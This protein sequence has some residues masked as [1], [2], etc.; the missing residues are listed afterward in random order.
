MLTASVD[1]QILCHRSV[2]LNWDYFCV[3]TDGTL[4]D[5]TSEIND[6]FVVRNVFFPK[7]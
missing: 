2:K 4:V 5:L 7:K 6:Y 1:L 3:T